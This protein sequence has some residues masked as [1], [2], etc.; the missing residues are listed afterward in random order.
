MQ[1][2]CII[3]IATIKQMIYIIFVCS[4]CLTKKK[5]SFNFYRLRRNDILPCYFPNEDMSIGHKQANIV[6]YTGGN[7]NAVTIPTKINDL[8]L[9]YFCCYL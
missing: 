6:H 3:I 7:Q 5:T 4:N 8:F 2:I 9:F 1:H